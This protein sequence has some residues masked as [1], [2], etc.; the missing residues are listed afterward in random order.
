MRDWIR[1]WKNDEK[2]TIK[3]TFE[4]QKLK[5][6]H[7]KSGT[8]NKIIQC[9]FVDIFIQ[10][11]MNV[12]SSSSSPSYEGITWKQQSHFV[13]SWM[14]QS[15]LTN[16]KKATDTLY[17]SI[18]KK[19]KLSRTQLRAREKKQNSMTLDVVLWKRSKIRC[20]AV[21]ANSMSWRE[22]K[23][24]TTPIC[25]RRHFQCPKLSWSNFKFKNLTIKFEYFEVRGPHQFIVTIVCVRQI[26]RYHTQ[27]Y[28]LLLILEWDDVSRS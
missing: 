14:T 15:L 5:V 26:Y 16:S 3:I 11:I 18:R 19:F 27:K 7:I 1:I 10:N 25:N 12:S 22:K 9:W 28:Q 13:N 2:T 23:G 20:P 8:Y 24:T 4:N 21:T 17:K 6:Q